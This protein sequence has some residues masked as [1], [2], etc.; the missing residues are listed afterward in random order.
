[1]PHGGKRKMA[2]IPIMVSAFVCF[3]YGIQLLACGICGE[4]LRGVEDSNVYRRVW[5]GLT[6]AG[7][8]ACGLVANWYAVYHM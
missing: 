4:D 2:Q 8:I 5:R 3:L 1:M 6:G 7:N